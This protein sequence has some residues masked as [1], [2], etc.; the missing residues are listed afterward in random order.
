MPIPVECGSCGHR[1]K[2]KDASAGRKIRCPECEEPIAVPAGGGG[3]KRKKRPAKKRPVPEEFDENADLDFGSLAAMERR[4]DSLGAGNVEPCP[5]CGEPVGKRATECPHCEADL[6]EVRG[7][8]KKK[9]KIEQRKQLMA[10]S[11]EGGLPKNFNQLLILGVLVAFGPLA[12]HIMLAEPLLPPAPQAFH[13]ALMIPARLWKLPDGYG[14]EAA[15]QLETLLPTINP[16]AY[17][18]K[19]DDNK[20][21]IYGPIEDKGKLQDELKTRINENAIKSFTFD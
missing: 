15:A 9:K 3:P 18:Q 1:L 11:R 5:E 12:M 16:R 2:A 13:D 4:G 6:V 8:I 21:A 17:V 19:D 20:Y 14:D 7:E 10:E